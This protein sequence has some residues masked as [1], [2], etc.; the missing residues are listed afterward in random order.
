MVLALSPALETKRRNNWQAPRRELEA[1]IRRSCAAL[2]GWASALGIADAARRIGIRTGTLA[3]WKDARGGACRGR[4]LVLTSA[5]RRNDVIGVIR[6]YG[7]GIGVPTLRLIFPDVPRRELDDLARRARVVAKKRGEESLGLRWTVAGAVWATDFTEA[8]IPIEGE[9]RSILLVRDLGSGKQLLALSSRNQNAAVV[10]AALVALFTSHGAPL[11]LKADNGSPFACPA[12][13]RL[14]K[15]CGVFLLLSPP[16]FPQY[17]GS[18]EAAGGALKT[19][20]H[21]IAAARGRPEAWTDDDL[22]EARLQGNRTAR[23]SSEPTPE[24]VWRARS[25]IG[26]LAR[27]LFAREIG[28]QR[29][30][31]SIERDAAGSD[32]EGRAGWIERTTITRALVA[33]GYLTMRRRR[34]AP[35]FFR[36][37]RRK[38]S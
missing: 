25:G 23:V 36:P 30:W 17:N 7:L 12:V 14:L 22:E 27:A 4:P 3:E 37:I 38:I 9:S 2:A 31:N 26:L 19:R 34:I 32:F 5:R 21:Y 20:V 33:R 8:P 24:A 28:A 16:H 35:R 11:V 15:T 13:R 29:T 1:E 10:C 6:A 18:C